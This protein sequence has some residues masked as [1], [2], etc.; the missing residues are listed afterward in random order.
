[1]AS[2]SVSVIIPT[3]DRISLLEK[4]LISVLSQTLPVNEIIVVDN[5]SSDGTQQMLSLSFPNVI[6][7]SE[8]KKGVSFA[9]NAGILIAKSDWIAFLDSDDEWMPKKN[10]KASRGIFS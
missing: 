9:R 5:G 4:A 1:M 10:G 7:I 3:L 2:F 6:A 8:T